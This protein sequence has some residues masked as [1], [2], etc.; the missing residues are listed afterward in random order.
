MEE[1]KKMLN[2]NRLSNCFSFRDEIFE[3]IK[4]GKMGAHI[5]ENAL[6]LFQKEHLG[7]YKFYYFVQDLENLFLAKDLLEKYHAQ[8]DV[9]LEF[10]SKRRYGLEELQPIVENLGFFLY[11]SIERYIPSKDD[12]IPDLSVK[13]GK[14]NLYATEEDAEEIFEILKNEFDC[15]M[16]TIP[17]VEEL[18]TKFIANKTLFIEKDPITNEIV[19]IQMYLLRGKTLDG[20]CNWLRKDYRTGT[21][22]IDFSA[23]T[24]IAL[25]NLHLN[26]NRLFG[27]FARSNK[28][29]IKLYTKI[30]KHKPD[31]VSC[32]I[33][34]Y[35]K[36]RT[37]ESF[38]MS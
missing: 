25:A 11:E 37:R 2:Q 15:L 3:N 32:D 17:S 29:V 21:N 20:F 9:V 6:F 5:V 16:V 7:F 30:F 19:Y 31:G 10:T 34:T 8:G 35:K 28:K 12:K 38:G 24:S 18:K 14:A 27:W 26:Y 13:E 23:G 36:K 33:F 4:T 1:I 22:W